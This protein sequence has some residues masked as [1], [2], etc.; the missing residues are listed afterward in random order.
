M[1]QKMGPLPEFRKCPKDNLPVAFATAGLDVAGPFLTKQ[2]R[3]KARHKRY[4]LLF[5]CTVF[6]AVHL[7]MLYG[8][9]TSDILLALQRF[10]S[11]RGLPVQLVSDNATYFRRAAIEIDQGHAS[12]VRG[13][14]AAWENV[15][16]LFNPPQ[17][18]HTG[19]VFERLIASSKRALLA[20]LGGAD[21][22]DDELSSAFVF[23]EG[24]L[25]N[26]PLDF[27]STDASD[28]SPLTPGHFLAGPRVQELAFQDLSR[29]TPFSRRWRH[30]NDVVDKYWQ[31][32]VEEVKPGLGLRN[33]W[34]SR[35]ENLEIGDVVV[36]L[37]EK[38]IQGRW[39]LG[40]ITELHPGRDGLVRMV[41]V[42]VQGRELRR[43]VS[44]MMP[45][46]RE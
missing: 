8:L 45:L 6:R 24:V 5:C 1:T 4:L 42:K 44:C 40:R 33:K 15:S 29:G 18:P 3:G 30:I 43:H 34:H 37:G 12:H 13:V 39:P 23:V 22:W 27:I 2:G 11:R 38:N 46:F 36:L 14:T 17:S 9:E 35:R 25:N 32:F 21:F 26:R 7:E 19:G 28:L 20:V 41:T 16:W 10:A 31:R